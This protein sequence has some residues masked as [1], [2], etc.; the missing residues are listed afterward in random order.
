[1][2]RSISAAICTTALAAFV[3]VAAN[4]GAAVAA[5]AMMAPG[6]KMAAMA[7]VNGVI[8][9]GKGVNL[10]CGGTTAEVHD[11][12]TGKVVASV[13]TTPA[14]GGSCAFTARVPAGIALSS[15]AGKVALGAANEMGGMHSMFMATQRTVVNG[16][17]RLGTL[18][19]SHVFSTVANISAL[20]GD[21]K[22]TANITVG[23]E[24]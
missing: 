14:G 13:P 5:D 2:M 9:G 18:G 16:H 7:T 22:S 17:E 15:C 12:T 6:M 19:S 3:L 20:N 10:D 23:T 8:S 4:P 21:G 24:Q 11:A 1:M